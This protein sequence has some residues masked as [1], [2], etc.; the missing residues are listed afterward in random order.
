MKLRQISHSISR[1]EAAAFRLYIL[2][3]MIGFLVFTVGP[4]VYSLYLA[5]T[6]TILGGSG[7][8]IGLHNFIFMFTKDPL[9]YTSLVNTAYYAALSVPLGLLIAFVLALLLNMKM[10]GMAL[11]RT[12]FYIPSVVNGVAVILL[13]GWIFNPSYGLLNYLLSI[14]GMK[15]P[16]WLANPASAMPAII[17]MSLWTI[18]GPMVIF[19]ASLQG[20]PAELF[21]SADIDGAGWWT[22]TIR[23]TIPSVSPV[24]FF[25][26]ILGLI[27]GLQVF[28]Q[29]YILTN[30]GPLNATT[31][32]VLNLFNY[33]FVYLK[34]GYGSALAWVLFIIILG[35]TLF[36]MR[37]SR[38]WVYY[39][40]T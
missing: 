16:D 32:Y 24:I 3:W 15:G 23:I 2:P 28:N 11:F 40:E 14:I 9:F 13:W 37:T 4:M 7:H 8:F 21:E 17:F 31:T 33:G 30:G 12:V 19:L 20:I 36:I 35:L 26:L 29:A 25:N 38:R 10:P 1:S 5:L 6:N 22:K 18:G 27:G 34:V 39:G